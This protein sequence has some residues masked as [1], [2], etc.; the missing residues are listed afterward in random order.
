M[1]GRLNIVVEFDVPDA[2]SSVVVEDGRISELS[3]PLLVLGS[4]IVSYAY[5]AEGRALV[6]VTPG[7][8]RVERFVLLG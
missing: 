5:Q 3:S 7:S 8:A 2:A 4:S 6:G 1:Q